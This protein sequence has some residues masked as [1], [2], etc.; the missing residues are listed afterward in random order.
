[1]RTWIDEQVAA[2]RFKPCAHLILKS[3][4]LRM[5]GPSG[6]STQ[7]FFLPTCQRASFEWGRY[8]G[9]DLE[10]QRELLCFHREFD[11]LSCPTKCKFYRNRLA[12]KIIGFVPTVLRA[13]RS[14]LRPPFQWFANLPG[15]TQVFLILLIVVLFAPKWI[16]LLID[17]VKAFISK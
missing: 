12:G 11:A 17:L 15:V 5:G 9:M 6:R 14:F 1:M 10:S 2:K 3:Q 16:P 8:S 4:T 7:I 13:L